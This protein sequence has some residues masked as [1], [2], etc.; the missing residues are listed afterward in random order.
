[1]SE[2][3]PHLRYAVLHHTGIAEP[4]YDLLI[5][6]TPNQPLATWRCETWPLGPEPA[7]S[8]RL[9]D[10]R[11]EY[12]SY[13][14]PVSANRGRVARV[15]GGTCNLRWLS[16]RTLDVACDDGSTLRLEAIGG[17]QWLLYRT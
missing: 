14:G 9:P 13:E 11:R 15:A 1:M 8:Q 4:H 17:D 7:S 12:L 16:P 10:H 5:E 3:M 2:E 6:L